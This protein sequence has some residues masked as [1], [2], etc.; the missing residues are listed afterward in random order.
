MFFVYFLAKTRKFLSILRY[1]HI[2][3]GSSYIR[4]YILHILTNPHIPAVLLFLDILVDP[5]TAVPSK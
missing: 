4:I 5:V 1:F 3:D 2:C